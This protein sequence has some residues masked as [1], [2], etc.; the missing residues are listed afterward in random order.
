MY[1]KM[2]QDFPT[3]GRELIL[4]KNQE[5][6]RKVS[7]LAPALYID[8]LLKPETHKA[9][10]RKDD[11]QDWAE[12][13]KLNFFRR[14]L[15]AAMASSPEYVWLYSEKGAWWDRSHVPQAAV[16]WERQ[17]PGITAVIESLRTPELMQI[18]ASA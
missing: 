13:G 8:P 12:L 18:P 3:L 10:Y 7:Q 1:Y 11:Q 4:R 14:Y 17:C 2:Q 9:R 6:F 15:A 5:K 16:S